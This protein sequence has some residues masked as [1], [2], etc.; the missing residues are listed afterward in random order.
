MKLNRLFYVVTM[1]LFAAGS[2]LTAAEFS[3]ALDA[4]L[5]MAGMSDKVSAIVILESP[6]DIRALDLK[7]HDTGAT[8]A[9]RHKD[10]IDA[11]K[12]N[13]ESTQPAFVEEFDAAMK[14]GQVFGFTAHWVENLFVIQATREYIEGLRGRGD[15]KY[16]TENFKAELIDPIIT[17]PKDATNRRPGHNLDTESTTP[18]QNATRATEVNRLLGITG[19]G[20]LV[21][22]LDTGVDGNHPALANRWRGN[23][24]PSAQCWLDLLGTGTTFPVDDGRHG[25]HVMGTMA[26][27]AISGVDTNT[28]GAAP[29]ARWIACNAINQGVSSGFDNDIITAFEWFTDPDGNPLTLDDVPDVIQNSWGVNATFPSGI[30]AGGMPCPVSLTS[31]TAQPS[32]LRSRTAMP[33]PSGVYLMAFDSRLSSTCFRRSASTCA[34][35]FGRKIDDQRELAGA[36]ALADRPGGLASTT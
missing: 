5:S 22:N 2:A 31:N 12:Y 32:S 21:A 33:P 20:V 13:A 19:Q 14:D 26:G 4:E 25:T 34:N 28:V 11:L 35:R 30:S 29:D 23:F 18:G 24:A 27:R 17:N 3:P 15:I 36:H 10:V 8:L 7:L 16:V 6:V 1:L 9:K